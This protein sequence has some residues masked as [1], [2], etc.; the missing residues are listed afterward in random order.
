MCYWAYV[1]SVRNW[2]GM[3]CKETCGD[4]KFTFGEKTRVHGNASMAREQQ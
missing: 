4:N 3:L 1:L 2:G